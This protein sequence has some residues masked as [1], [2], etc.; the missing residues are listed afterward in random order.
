[1]GCV[2]YAERDPSSRPRVSGLAARCHDT[3][4]VRRAVACGIPFED[5]PGM[6]V[7]RGRVGEGGGLRVSREDGGHADQSRQHHA[8]DSW[9]DCRMCCAQ[10]TGHAEYPTW[11]TRQMSVL[12]L[13]RGVSH[14]PWLLA[15]GSWQCVSGVLWGSSALS[16][17]LLRC[18]GSA[19]YLPGELP[20]AKDIHP[21]SITL[22]IDC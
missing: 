10:N 2:S 16:L 7:K 3:F 13:A 20:T 21:R 22:A 8:G 19:L 12:I 9:W 4:A 11:E 5:A 6:Y 17:P 14:D 1:M 15:V 18:G